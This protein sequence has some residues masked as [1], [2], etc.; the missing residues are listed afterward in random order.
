MC[1]FMFLFFFKFKIQEKQDTIY[2]LRIRKTSARK[3]IFTHKKIE[4]KVNTKIF[5]NK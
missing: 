5:Q 3:E 1:V 2:K 4:H